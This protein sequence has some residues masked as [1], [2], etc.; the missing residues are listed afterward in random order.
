MAS[1]FSFGE[2]VRVP[3]DTFHDWSEY[4]IW[5]DMHSADIEF[6][7]EVLGIDVSRRSEPGHD[8]G[9]VQSCSNR[10]RGACDLP[11]W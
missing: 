1:E 6:D 8:S 5:L 3:R 11:P 4:E 7:C 2:P 10:D 9:K